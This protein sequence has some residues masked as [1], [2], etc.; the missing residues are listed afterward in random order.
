[1]KYPVRARIIDI[2]EVLPGALGQIPVISKPHVG[3]EGTANQLSNGEIII[4]LD[5][6]GKL[7]GWECWW[8]PIESST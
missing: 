7:W 2:A 8:E 3:K 1:M 4:V 5:G 6:G